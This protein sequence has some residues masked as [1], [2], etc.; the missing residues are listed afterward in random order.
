M[1]P[2]DIQV[3]VMRLDQLND[4]LQDIHRE[5]K[6]TNGRVTQLEKDKAAQQAVE[7]ALRR[8]PSQL[9]AQITGMVIGGGA[10]ALLVWFVSNSVN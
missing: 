3:I 5:V 6:T 7:Q 1:T 8:R 10:L 9:I 2:A 4:T